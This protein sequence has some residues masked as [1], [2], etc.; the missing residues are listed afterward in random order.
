MP[1]VQTNND[2]NSMNITKQNCNMS[3]FTSNLK[4]KCIF[5][6]FIVL[7]VSLSNDVVLNKMFSNNITIETVT[8]T[9]NKFFSEK[10]KD[11]IED[12]VTVHTD[13]HITFS[14]NEN[15]LFFHHS[16]ISSKIECK[17]EKN[18]QIFDNLNFIY[19]FSSDFIHTFSVKPKFLNCFSFLENNENHF[20]FISELENIRKSKTESQLF[21]RIINNR[22]TIQHIKNK[23][24]NFN[25]FI[26]PKI[27]NSKFI[28]FADT[29]CH[30]NKKYGN[31]K[32]LLN[33]INKHSNEV[34]SLIHVGDMS[35]ATDDGNCY[36]HRKVKNNDP[37]KHL[38]S[39]SCPAN[40]TKCEGRKR[41]R[42]STENDWKYFMSETKEIMSKKILMTNTGNHD[43]DIYWFYKFRPPH[44]SSF[45]NI[46]FI[47][48]F[49]KKHFEKYKNLEKK[50]F[51][52]SLNDHQGYISEILQ[53][54]Y[55]YSFSKV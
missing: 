50:N 54:P 49:E 2:Q 1:S 43:N 24:F 17:N 28:I 39:Y 15:N 45:L 31:C 42:K 6:V 10:N 37:M 36:K 23:T 5:V 14:E 40:N 29:D 48:D 12:N 33:S 30:I 11:L 20:F 21:Y 19:S 55:F 25:S 18:M 4:I 34:S 16:I 35:Y 27:D 8:Q 13:F 9:E 52:T 51:S 47:E 32:A 44:K 46:N 38:C 3:I 7:F 53:N 26:I 41:N 22:N